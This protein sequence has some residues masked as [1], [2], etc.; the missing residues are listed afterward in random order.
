VLF[1]AGRR[2]DSIALEADAHHLMTDV[3]TSVAVAAGVGATALTGWHRL[4]PLLALAVAAQV[5]RLG[6]N[7]LR[8][9][10]LGL[11]DTALPEPIRTRITA[12][13]ESHQLHGVEYHALRTRQAG[14]RRFISFHILVP[15]EWTV[16]QGHDLLERIEEEVR[17]AIPNSTV[18]THLE[19]LEDP[20]S[21]EDTRL[22][23]ERKEQQL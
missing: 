15:G 2:Y 6:I 3:W 22:E 23:R 11:L 19:P 18:F 14:A 1:Q 13:L 12:I 21:F 5:I 10:M 9:S 4:D 17:A 20:V 8:R 16:Q 7:L